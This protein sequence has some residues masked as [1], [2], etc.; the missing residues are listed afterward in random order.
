MTSNDNFLSDYEKHEK[1]LKEANAANKPS[2]FVALAAAGITRVEVTFDGEGDSGQM[3]AA[4]FYRGE[5]RCEAPNTFIPFLEV[6]WDKA[7]PAEKTL[8]NAIECLCYD[9]L[10]Q[11]HGGWENNDGA[12]GEFIFDATSRQIELEFSVRYTDV[13]NYSD[14]F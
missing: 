10:S 12:F 14:T 5:A 6:S 7:R 1:A 9:Y 13:T 11:E 2:V 4:V 3:E 8:L